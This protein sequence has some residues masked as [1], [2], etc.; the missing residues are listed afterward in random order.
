M[1]LDRYLPD[2]LFAVLLVFARV[3]SALVILPGF[4][5][6]YVPQRYRLLLAVFLSLLIAGIVAPLLPALPSS[7]ATLL[8]LL[9]GEIV[10]GLFLGTVARLLVTALETAGSIVA[11]QVGLS[12]ASVFNPMMAQQSALPS[13][14]LMT[15]GTLVIF[16]TDTHHLLLRA[17]VDSYSL[18]AP[19]VMP[20]LGDAS[21]MV[22]RTAAASFRLGTELAA[23]F[24]VAGTLF[25]AALGLLSRLMPQLQIFFVIVPV[26]IAGGIA[27]FALTLSAVMR[28]FAESFAQQ[29]GNFLSP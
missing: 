10:V 4:G 18:F 29:I 11:L 7:P 1:P 26:Q 13:S 2:N 16:L 14:L 12:S 5:D 3:G 17:L 22:A 25:F 6:L 28:W 27:I 21:D 15:L 19:G 8:V 20:I 9:F 24:I 23:P